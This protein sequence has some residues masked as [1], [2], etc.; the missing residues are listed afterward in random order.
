MK[1]I[2]FEKVSLADAKRV[3]DGKPRQ[4]ARHD[5][6]LRRGANDHEEPLREAMTTWLADLPDNVRPLR[7]VERFPR[8]AN[9]ICALWKQPVRCSYYM[10]DLLIV[11][12]EKRQGFPLVIGKEIGK[13][14]AHYSTLH[15][16]GAP[17]PRGVAGSG[18]G[19]H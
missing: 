11:R 6:S 16:P 1:S 3:H 8:I 12:R 17:G 14:I 5:G 9:K 4:V 10:A 15:D 18:L 19:N 13:L 7:L 2:M